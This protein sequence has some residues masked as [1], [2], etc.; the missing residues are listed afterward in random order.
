VVGVNLEMIWIN[1]FKRNPCCLNEYNMK[2]NTQTILGIMIIASLLPSVMLVTSK[3][4]LS[5]AASSDAQDFMNMTE[6][7]RVQAAKNMTQEEKQT[8]MNEFSKQ[9]STVDENMSAT[10]TNNTKPL[11]GNFVGSGDG[12]H[13]AEGIAKVITLADGKTFLRLENLKATNG[14][15][16]YVYLSTG[17]DVSDIVNLGRLKGNIGNQNY[18]IPTGTD[19]S[20]HNTVLI[21]CKAFST[22][23]GSAILSSQ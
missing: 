7:Q 22:L 4:Q 1:L 8:V 23:F 3:S 21:W 5:F 20:K 6:E 11:M 2:R 17:K 15:D 18:E 19:L 16:L 13:K 12:F 9:N 14:P 10:M